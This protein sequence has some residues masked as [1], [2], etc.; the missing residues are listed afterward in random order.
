MERKKKKEH[1]QEK[2]NNK[3]DLKQKSIRWIDAGTKEKRS[4]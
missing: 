1:R 3:N 4:Y 2:K